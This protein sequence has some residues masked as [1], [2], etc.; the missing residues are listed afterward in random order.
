MA[1]YRGAYSGP[2]IDRL[3]AKADLSDVFSE[4]RLNGLS[5]EQISKEDFDSLSEKDADKVYF[6]YD[7]KGKVK[8]YIGEAEL[9]GPAFTAGK[10]SAVS[11]NY[12]SMLTGIIEEE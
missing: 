4:Q 5:F 8:Q 12:V 2:E 3:L 6:V 1:V 7:E 11:N 9:G 10:M